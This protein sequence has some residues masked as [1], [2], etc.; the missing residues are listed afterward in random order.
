LKGNYITLALN[1]TTSYSFDTVAMHIFIIMFF[2][3]IQRLLM[4]DVR[5][6]N[7]DVATTFYIIYICQ[8]QHYHS[9]LDSTSLL[10]DSCSLLV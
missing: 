6:K 9:L 10:D 7:S 4:K 3:I 8:D 1:A 2:V 5:S